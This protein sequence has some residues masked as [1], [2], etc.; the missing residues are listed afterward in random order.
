MR[1]VVLVLSLS[2][3]AM[4]T[5]VGAHGGDPDMIHAC[6]HKDRRDGE[7]HGRVRIVLPNEECRRKEAPVHWSVMGP[8]GPAGPQG[9]VG[10]AGPAGPAGGGLTVVDSVGNVVGYVTGFTFDGSQRVLPN[11]VLQQNGL[12]VGL[13]VTPNGFEG[14][15]G[16]L[17]FARADCQEQAFLAGDFNTLIL[18]ATIEAPGSTVYV[19]NPTAAPGPVTARSLLQLGTC[20]SFE[21]GLPLAVPALPLVDLNTL[22]TPPF[23]IK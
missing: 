22:F 1:G 4:P 15:G 23:S 16:S 11:I 8:A 14:S 6:V 10:P 20:F 3:L 17:A 19:P 9:L 18:P 21:F 7:V 13:M 5:A 2:I 12:R